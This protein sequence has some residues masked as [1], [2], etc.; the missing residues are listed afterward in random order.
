MEI[1]KK[2]SN[3]HEF[4]VLRGFHWGGYVTEPGQKIIMGMSEAMSCIIARRVIP[5]DLPDIGAYI[6]L[7]D[8][9]LPGKIQAHQAKRLEVV[10]L[11]ASDALRLMM[12]SKIIPQDLDQWRPNNRRLREGPD[13]TAEERAKNEKM[14]L[15][16]QLFKIGIHPSQ[17]PK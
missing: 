16:D 7:C 3:Q 12:E 2:R 15:D 4:K 13:R 11:K 9:I 14:V 17:R 1:V 5:A 10:E 6:C 8:L